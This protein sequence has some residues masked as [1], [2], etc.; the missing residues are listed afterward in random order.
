VVSDQI[1]I[2]DIL[3]GSKADLVP[4][5][6]E[7]LAAAA[8]AAGGA[9]AAAAAAA[10]ASVAAGAEAAGASG[11]ATGAEG[12]ASAAEGSPPPLKISSFLQWAT[13]LYP[14]KAEV[15]TIAGGQ[16]DPALL[17][18][19]RSSAFATLTA[20]WRQPGGSG[21]RR[22]GAV[23]R[24]AAAGS[25]PAAQWWEEEGG[26]D[27][28]GAAAPPAAAAAAA[29]SSTEAAAEQHHQ[30]QQPEPRKP[31]RL[32]RPSSTPLDSAACGWIFHTSDRFNRPRLLRLLQQL[33]PLVGRIKGVCRVAAAEWVL[34][35]LAL[36]AAGQPAVALSTICYR[37]D[38]CVEVILRGGSSGGGGWRTAA[39]TADG[40]GDGNGYG[41]KG[42]AA[43]AVAAAQGGNWDALEALLLDTLM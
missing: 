29:G 10:A 5:S 37:G 38:S 4:G 31:A 21:R 40:G 24:Q 26:G 42:V 34:P 35:S 22:G 33:T 25:Q 11:G 8:A 16:L 41:G 7:A 6:T 14:P 2:A 15:L 18:R 12:S 43:A 1:A 23:R 9:A 3:V 27:E 30:Q 19:P 36:D 32:Q 20:G 13:R 28:D 39:A 17:D